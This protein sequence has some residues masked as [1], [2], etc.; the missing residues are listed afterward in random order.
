MSTEASPSLAAPV[1]STPWWLKL[2]NHNPFYVISTVLM[3]I[4]V[5]AAY[6]EMPIGEIN[7]WVV[8]GVLAGY[9]TLLALIGICIIRFG[10]IWE[11]A[12]SILLLLLLLFLGISVSMDDL[13]VKLESP[14]EGAWLALAGVAFSY[15]ITELVLV[16]TK[17]QLR[18]RY[19][20]PYYLFLV[21]FFFTPWW[22]S[23]ELNPRSSSETEWLLLL[24]PVV[25]AGILLLLLP[26]VWGG[27]K[28]VRNNGTPWK[29]P[30][31]PWSMFFMLIVATIIRSYALC[32]TFG[33]TGPIWHKLSGGGVGI[34]F[35]TIWGTWFLVPILW[36]ILLLLLEGGI[37][38]HSTTQRKWSLILAPALI[39]LAFPFGSSSV[40][41]TFWDR[42]LT[43][44]GSPIWIATL[45]VILFYGWATLRKVSGA[46]Y[47]F[48]SF[49]LLLAW[50][51]PSTEQ[52]PALIPQRAWPIALVG[53]GL[54]MKG[55]K[56]HSS[57]YQTTASAMLISSV[58]ILIQQS[59]Y[60]QWTTEATFILVW[61][62]ALILGACHRDDLGCFLRFV[63]STQAILI[64][65]QILT[66]TMPLELNI[67]YRLLI[68]VVLTGFCLLL[69]FVMK[70]RWYLFAFSGNF[71]LLLYGAVLIG[72]QQASSQFGSTALLTFSW[73]LG[74]LL[75]AMLIS[76]H[77]AEWLPRRFIPKNW[78]A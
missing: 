63:A 58:A 25:A 75:F 44:V 76:A 30:L 16:L 42:M 37:V 50:I 51:D 45:L 1:K 11:D 46:F 2:Y 48:V 32:L 23:P 8:M 36:A 21:L 56:E 19:R 40:F 57:F 62:T 70:N 47:G 20:I 77:K 52:W 39:L 54:L 17:I 73:S 35:S 4:S 26:A 33:P 34:V 65:Y 61:L 29:W 3:L 10:K 60:A 69:A 9:T 49:F 64:G 14:Q 71:L 5:R 67:G 7:C 68:L 31:F 22:M 6:G 28:Y 24:F 27:P 66:R 72:Y 15:V 78:T 74:M 59:S 41:T 13:F 38:S 12:R 43:T 55:F 53:F 18:A